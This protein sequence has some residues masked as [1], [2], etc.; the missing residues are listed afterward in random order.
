MGKTEE[1]TYLLV[2]GPGQGLVDV[3]HLEEGD[4]PSVLLRELRDVGVLYEAVVAGLLVLGRLVLGLVVRVVRLAVVVR[5]VVH[6]VVGDPV[7][8][9]PQAEP[10]EKRE[11]ESR[12]K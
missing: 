8:A 11:C 2:A 1:R 3:G 12:Q 5:R 4:G 6:A 10:E 7:R 9:G